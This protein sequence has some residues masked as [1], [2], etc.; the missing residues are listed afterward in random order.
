MSNAGG[1]EA[2]CCKQLL[3]IAHLFRIVLQKFLLLGFLFKEHISWQC[4][5]SEDSLE[6][7]SNDCI[8]KLVKLD[9]RDAEV[10][11][12]INISLQDKLPESLLSDVAFLL[13]TA[14]ITW[15]ISADQVCINTIKFVVSVLVIV[16]KLG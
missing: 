3:I 4:F 13:R 11:L 15:K 10:L 8:I 1:L 14:R 7:V 5:S 9:K 6:L 12:E 16:A 2:P